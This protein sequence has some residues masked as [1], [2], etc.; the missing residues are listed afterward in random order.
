MTLHVLKRTRRT[1]IWWPRDRSMSRKA[2]QECQH[3]E[4][5]M[6][7]GHG[8]LDEPRVGGSSGLVERARGGR[9]MEGALA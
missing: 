3:L 5:T 1:W 7:V 2:H 8:P 4:V 9:T 6:G